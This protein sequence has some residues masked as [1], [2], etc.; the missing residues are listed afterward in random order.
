M[1]NYVY[2]FE[3][4]I[5]KKTKT[6]GITIP[7]E[8]I[9]V[10]KMGPETSGHQDKYGARRGKWSTDINAY[11]SDNFF[12]T[13]SLL[14]E[15]GNSIIKTDSFLFMTRST[16]DGKM[17]YVYSS[18]WK[19]GFSSM[20]EVVLP[21]GEVN[22]GHTFTIM[23]TNEEQVFL[24]LENHG[25]ESP[26]GSLYISDA[27]ARYYTLSLKN[28]IKGSAIDFERVNS[29]DGTFIANI[30]QPE[31]LEG[32]RSSESNKRIK[33]KI[34]VDDDEVFYEEDLVSE[35]RKQD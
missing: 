29:L 15:G 22:I 3:W 31:N 28:V 25:A 6:Q 24:F 30:Y 10:T 12:K 2:D 8:R 14:L 19:T 18:T 21:N 16:S 35:M 20:K 4:A 26:F 5:S 1:T 32:F 34:S 7:N 27:D 17:V 23:D 33:G 11:I 9:I 13:S